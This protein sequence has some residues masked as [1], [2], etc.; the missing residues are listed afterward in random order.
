MET[1]DLQIII[2]ALRAGGFK[3][4]LNI[5]ERVIHGE[6]IGAKVEISE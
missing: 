3:M 2:L 5:G 1:L 6:V 4:G